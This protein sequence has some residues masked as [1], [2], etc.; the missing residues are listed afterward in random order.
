MVTSDDGKKTQDDVSQSESE[1]E[2]YYIHRCLHYVRYCRFPLKE[3]VTTVAY[4]YTSRH[5]PQDWVPGERES[6]KKYSSVAS[7]SIEL[8]G[9]QAWGRNGAI[10]LT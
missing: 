3:N 6:P 8:S 5:L 4:A 1:S 7:G 9:K 10:G 2:S